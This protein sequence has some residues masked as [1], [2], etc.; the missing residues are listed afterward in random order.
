TER[1]L[2]DGIGPSNQLVAAGALLS[3][4][5][6]SHAVIDM[7]EEAR[8]VEMNQRLITNKRGVHRSSELL[9]AATVNGANSLGRN[10][11]GLVVGA[12][13][14]FIAISTASVRLASFDPKNGAA[15]L[16]HSATS[17]DVRD[18]WV[19]GDQ[20]VKD[21]IHRTMPDIAG[22]LRS[23]INALL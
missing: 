12:A 23:A 10:S 5:S 2:A 9:N 15:H 18:V 4:G 1:D 14:D 19:G 7:F 8:A 6:D 11:Y 17:A 3:L 21:Q 16:V 22:V 20:I 13:A